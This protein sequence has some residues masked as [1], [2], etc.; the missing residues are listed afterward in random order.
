MGLLLW[1]GVRYKMLLFH[2]S[3]GVYESHS[4]TLRQNKLST[5]VLRIGNLT[6]SQ[7]LFSKKYAYS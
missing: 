4:F 3:A 7:H 1:E 2:D 6:G 5:F